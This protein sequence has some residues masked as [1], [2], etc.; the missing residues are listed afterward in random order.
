[1]RSGTHLTDLGPLGKVSVD[2][3]MTI[4]GTPPRNMVTIDADAVFCRWI[5]FFDQPDGA[6]DFPARPGWTCGRENRSMRFHNGKPE[7]DIVILWSLFYDFHS[8]MNNETIYM[9]NPIYGRPD[10]FGQLTASELAKIDNLAQL[11]LNPDKD[12]D[13]LVRIFETD[14]DFRLV[15]GALI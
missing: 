8:L 6:F 14:R 3:W 15:H 9:H 13:E 10:R 5:W 12:F 7:G 11:M 4:T 1:V 2:H